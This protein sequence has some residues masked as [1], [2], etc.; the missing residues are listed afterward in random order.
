MSSQANSPLPPKVPA[1]DQTLR[2]LKLLAQARGPLPA[3]MIAHRLDLPRSTVYHLLATLQKHGFVLHLTEER[4]YGLGTAVVELNSAYS[5]QEPLTRLGIPVLSALTDQLG[6]STH[7]ALLHGTDVLYVVEQRAPGAPSLVTDVGVRLPAH[8]T[9]SGRAILSIMPRAQ[10]RALFPNTQSFV[11]RPGSPTL[12]DRYSKLRSVLDETQLRGF[13]SEREEI[14]EGLSSV[15]VA[16]LDHRG[17]PVASIAATFRDEELAEHQWA[18][19][20]ALVRETADLLTTRLHGRPH[21]K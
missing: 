2:I 3:S 20:A 10:V 17:W 4:R 9:A 8:L 11:H 6:M 15:G 13:S 21:A 5:R 1:A 12:I 7:L 18:E 14:T 19:T 16:V